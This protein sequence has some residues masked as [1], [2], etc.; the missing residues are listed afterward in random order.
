ML[1]TEV[2]DAAQGA[3]QAAEAPPVTARVATEG[4]LFAEQADYHQPSLRPEPASDGID[5]WDTF[6]EDMEDQE[7]RQDLQQFGIYRALP[8]YGEPDFSTAEPQTAEEYI[9]RVR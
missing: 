5:A 3:H 1:D 4:T 2:A 6:P 7:T 9:R 8:V